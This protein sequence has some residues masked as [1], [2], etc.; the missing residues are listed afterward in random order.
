AAEYDGSALITINSD[1]SSSVV[2]YDE[3]GVVL[4]S[5]EDVSG[6]Y[7]IEGLYG[8]SFYVEVTSDEIACGSMTKSFSISQPSQP[9]LNFVSNTY[10][11]CSEP[12]AGSITATI[13]EDDWTVTVI[14]DGVEVDSF[15]MYGSEILV[16][17]LSEG[18][19]EIVASNACGNSHI[20]VDLHNHF[21]ITADFE[22][23]SFIDLNNVPSAAYINTS[24][25]S[26]DQS[27]WEIDGLFIESADLGT[28]TFSEPG[29]YEIRLNIANL[30]CYD[31]HEMT[32]T[33]VGEALELEEVVPE[34]EDQFNAWFANDHIW[35]SG[36]ADSGKA[37]QMQIF[38]QDGRLVL[39]EQRFTSSEQSSLA[40]SNW[41]AGIYTIRITI[42]G[43]EVMTKSVVIAE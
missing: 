10:P 3:A 5:A 28:W 12:N 21:S 36:F 29:E 20:L 6:E 19:Y 13:T 33:V 15:D 24:D 16:E 25:G 23:P 30:A 2:W 17:E 8:G 9:D 32:V 34:E 40:I 35:L 1:A 39:D 14:Q 42:E 22:G 4:G 11:S 27:V 43:K 18:E 26:F 41:S 38:G 37:M 31:S 7:L